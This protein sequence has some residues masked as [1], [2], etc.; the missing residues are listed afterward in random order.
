MKRTDA[1]LLL[2][3]LFYFLAGVSK[4]DIQNEAESGDSRQAG[5]QQ[6]MNP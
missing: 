5:F 2:V 4:A 6:E 3:Y 1:V